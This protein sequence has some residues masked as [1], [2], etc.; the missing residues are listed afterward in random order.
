[1]VYFFRIAEIIQLVTIVS[2]ARKATKEMQ[3]K[4]HPMIVERIVQYRAY[5]IQEE[6]CDQIV[7]MVVNVFAKWVLIYV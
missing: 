7:P 1:M 4:V 3:H 6:V 2:S 5:V